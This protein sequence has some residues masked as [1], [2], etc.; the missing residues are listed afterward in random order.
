MLGFVLIV[1]FP[2]I[3]GLGFGVAYGVSYRLSRGKELLDRFGILL[4]PLFLTLPF[5][6]AL[7]TAF[8]EGIFTDVGVRLPQ[9]LGFSPLLSLIIALV[10]GVITGILLF[11]NERFLSNF[12]YRFVLRFPLLRRPLEGGSEESMR[13]LQQNPLGL[14]LALS[15]FITFGEEFLWRGYLLNYLGQTLFMPLGISLLISSVSFG[16]IH[17]Y[18]GLRNVLLK[19]LSGLI[20]G[21]LYW[22]TGSLVVCVISHFTFDCAAV[23]VQAR[24]PK[25]RQ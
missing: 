13:Q 14:F 2:I 8:E 23:L 6:V 10:G 5:A 15:A 3:L 7:L 22:F 24:R 19:T 25:V 4:Y 21:G 16:L 1:A 17:Y 12:L 18:F 20:W 11:Y 9:I